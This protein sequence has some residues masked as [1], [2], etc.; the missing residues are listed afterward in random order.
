MGLRNRVGL[1]RIE[2]DRVG[3]SGEWDRVALSG[4]EWH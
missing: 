2:R 1:S 4:T 3:Q